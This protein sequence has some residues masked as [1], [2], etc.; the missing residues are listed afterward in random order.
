L[1]SKLRRLLCQLVS[2]E[3]TADCIIEARGWGKEKSPSRNARS[4]RESNNRILF[5]LLLSACHVL[6]GRILCARLAE[7]PPG[8]RWPYQKTCGFLAVHAMPVA[9]SLYRHQPCLL[10]VVFL[11]YLAESSG[12]SHITQQRCAR[13][14]VEHSQ[15]RARP[16]LFCSSCFDSS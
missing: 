6:C 7:L 14:S 13:R 5:F 16:H 10:M 1:L 9:Q 4:R 11:S 8:I 15:R 12:A 2:Q 3:P